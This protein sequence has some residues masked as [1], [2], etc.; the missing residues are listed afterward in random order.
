MSKLAGVVVAGAL[1]LT[2]LSTGANADWKSLAR[3]IAP[4]TMPSQPQPAPAATVSAGGVGLDL[5]AAPATQ[6]AATQPT[7]LIAQAVATLEQVMA[8]IQG[9]KLDLA[10]TLLKQVEK[11]KSALPLAL[12]QR[13]DSTRKLLDTTKAAAAS[14]G[15]NL[16]KL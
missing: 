3:S 5:S 8:D 12:Q 11:Y 15:F 9:N 16:P 10:E 7:E 4:T 14:A 6:P 2:F 13:V 1:C